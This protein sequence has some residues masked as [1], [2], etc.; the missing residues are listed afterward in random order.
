LG[1]FLVFP[2]RLAFFLYL[3][4]DIIS[5]LREDLKFLCREA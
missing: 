1:C 3:F 4:Y 2:M 5:F